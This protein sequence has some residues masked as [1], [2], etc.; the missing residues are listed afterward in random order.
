MKT[1]LSTLVLVLALIG[2]QPHATAAGSGQ[3]ELDSLAATLADKP[4]V[5][6]R[7]GPAM[8]S[9][10]AETLRESNPELA[11]VLASVTGLR[12][13][14]FENVD[15]QAAE[16]QIADIIADLNGEG[17]APA[18]QVQDD[19][20]LIDLYMIESGEFVKGLTLLLRDGTDTVVFANIHGDLDPVVIGK[21]IGSGQAMQ[22]MDFDELMGQIQSGE[23]G[24]Q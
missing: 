5:N 2:F 6:I 9:G 22:G 10:F 23:N 21:L 19:E 1:V 16:P 12:L 20:T 8:M 14:V 17:W 15:S 13:M 3:V 4:K 11:D 18:I 7:F 24:D